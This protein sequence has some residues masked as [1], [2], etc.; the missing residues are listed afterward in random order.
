MISFRACAMLVETLLG[1]ENGYEK[2]E[3]QKRGSSHGVVIYPPR[4][5]H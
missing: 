1:N 4:T 2:K 3:E 5:R